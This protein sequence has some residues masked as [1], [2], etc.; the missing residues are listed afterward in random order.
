MP[1]EAKI[2]Q[3]DK[4]RIGRRVGDK[5][6]E[7][8]KVLMEVG[9]MGRAPVSIALARPTLLA[10]QRHTRHGHQHCLKRYHVG[11]RREIYIAERFMSSRSLVQC[12]RRRGD[13]LL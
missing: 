3:Y 1:G 5:G 10:F 6:G 8:Y 12:I 11:M 4:Q 2:R 13:I 9:Q 7:T